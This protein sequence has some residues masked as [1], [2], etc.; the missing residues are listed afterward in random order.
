VSAFDADMV[1][2]FSA[3]FDEIEAD[4]RARCGHGQKRASDA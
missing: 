1:R 2:A 4:E 3:A